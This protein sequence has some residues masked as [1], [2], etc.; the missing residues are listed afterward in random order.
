MKGES[1]L[2]REVKSAFAADEIVI[3]VFAI[4]R[5]KTGLPLTLYPTGR[6][7]VI[8][9]DKRDKIARALSGR[10]AK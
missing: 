7:L 1:R 10:C 8:S 3:P 5:T 6:T 9:A 4:D 2:K